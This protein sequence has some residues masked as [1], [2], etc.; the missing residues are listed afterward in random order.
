MMLR[1]NYL[2]LHIKLY[3]RG[4]VRLLH[5]RDIPTYWQPVKNPQSVGILRLY[6]NTHFG[7]QKI[8]DVSL[9]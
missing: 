9:T 7:F 6:G 5:P 3:K 8:G 2:L 1:T 4:D